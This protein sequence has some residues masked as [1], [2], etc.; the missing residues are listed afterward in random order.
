MTVARTAE[1]MVQLQR[2]A[3]AAVAYGLDCELIGPDKAVELYPV[4]GPT[5]WPGRS[6]C[7]GTGRPTPRT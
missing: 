7:P 6:G 4:I 3:A 5:T 1:R 2:T